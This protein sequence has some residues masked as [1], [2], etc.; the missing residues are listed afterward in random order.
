[1]TNM[2]FV[3]PKR[4]AFGTVSTALVL[5]TLGTAALPACAGA[6]LARAR[7][8]STRTL[9]VRDEARLRFV[10]S[11]GSRL[12]DEGHAT[13]TFAGPVR[14]QFTYTGDPA[15]TA[16]FTISGSGGSITARG[17]GTLSDPTTPNPSFRGRMTITGGT[18][19]Y[20]HIRGSGELFGVF[21][22]RNYGLTVQAFAELRY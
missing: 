17:S 7:A 15:V 13:G 18:G 1:M 22:R 16:Q 12:L 10:R 3:F 11:S 14:A 8:A 19:R 4:P 5:A 9:D 21:N 6:G 20:S 2:P